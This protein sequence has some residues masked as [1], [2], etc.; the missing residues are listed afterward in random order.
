VDKGGKGSF[1][2]VMAGLRHLREHRVEWNALTTVHAANQSRGRDVYRFLRDECDARFMQFIPIVE[3]ATPGTLPIANEG[4][5]DGVRDRPL[6]TQEGNLLTHRSIAPDGYGR[7]L[8]DVFEEWVRRD[9]GEVY[10]QMFDVALA[11]WYGEPPGLCV[12]SETCGLALAM[13]HTGDVYSCDHFVE[14]KYRLGN[15]KNAHL[16]EL[17]MLPQQQQFGQ[18]KRDTL[19]RFCRECDVRFACHGGC[20]KDRFTDDP[21]GEPGLNY[22]CPSYKAFFHHIDGTMTTM[23]EL[24]RAGRAP[25]ELVRQYA[26]EDAKRGRNEPCTC[27]S[28]RKWKLCHGDETSRTA[29]RTG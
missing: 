13:E 5:G 14:P 27:G 9:V 3:R 24:L 12:H 23:S 19:P 16:R 7:F 22:L 11:N 4:W 1:D 26:L 29:A 17:V 2:R 20:P 15:I 28:G 10:V 21:Y 25:S 18:D 6:Y 8:I